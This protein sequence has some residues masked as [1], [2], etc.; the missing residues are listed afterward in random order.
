MIV[1]V[2]VLGVQVPLVI[3]Q[4]NVFTPVV[5]PVTP[6]VGLDGVV[7]VAVPAVTVQSPVPTVGALAANVAV[8]EQIVWSAPAAATVGN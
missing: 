7:T 1:I 4:T 2:S 8:G 6:L 3:V 5:K